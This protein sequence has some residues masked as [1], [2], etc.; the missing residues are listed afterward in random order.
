MF[1]FVQFYTTWPLLLL[2]AHTFRSHHVLALC[3]AKQAASKT[4]N[5]L[6]LRL[7]SSFKLLRLAQVTNKYFLKCPTPLA[8]M[9]I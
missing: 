5:F 8:I 2:H 9:E 4:Q 6:L 7:I 3:V 1:L